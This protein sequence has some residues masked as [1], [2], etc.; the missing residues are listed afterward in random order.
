MSLRDTPT[1]YG[2]VSRL[3]HWIGA[4]LVILMLGIGLYFHEMPRGDELRYWMGLH[5]SIGALAFL[6]LA[7]RV[8]WRLLATSPQ[9]L[10]QKPW[11]Q[12]TS[13]GT[14]ALMLG[15]IA[16][17]IL[18]GPLTV[19]SG[20]RPIDVFGW[21]AMP[22]PIGEQEELHEALE[23]VH[24]VGSRLLLLTV[25]LH[26]LAAVWHALIERNRAAMA[27]MLGAPAR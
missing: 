3:N 1:A 6:A 7:F 16:V 9:P 12:R 11:L 5:I 23:V 24:A 26:V 15:L 22:S 13:Q 14:H 10:P 21:F 27:R 17:M 2:T 4:A 8:L 25:I 19:W 18:S 20:G